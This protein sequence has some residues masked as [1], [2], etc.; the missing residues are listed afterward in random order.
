MLTN[1]F[2]INEQSHVS[3]FLKEL[4]D[5]K[6][7]HYIILDSN[8][9]YFVDIRSIALSID[10]ANEKLKRFKKA[11]SFSNG[12]SN[13]E[14][15]TFLINSGDKVI[16]TNSGLFDFIEGLR[17]IVDENMDL[18]NDK[19][20]SIDRDKIFALNSE[21]LISNARALLV[22]NKIN[23][24]PVIN[25]NHKLLGEVRTVDFLSSGLHIPN[26]QRGD[27]YS[28]KRADSILNL[29]VENIM[30]PKP[31]TIDRK[32][33]IK[34]VIQIMINK[35]L[36][37][38]IVV[39]ND[40]VHSVISYKD[41]FKSIRKNKLE[42]KSFSIEIIGTK[43]LFDDE[44]QVIEDY[45]NKSM[46]KI[47]KVSN[48][49][50]LRIKFKPLGNTLGTHMKKYEI[51]MLLSA[52]NKVL[53]VEREIIQGTSDEEFNDK[54]KGKWNLLQIVQEGLHVLEKKVLDVK[55]RSH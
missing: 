51:K 32:A 11:L 49:N 5:K 45:A 24:L 35:N 22:K 4:K 53:T 2:Q 34:D 30:N 21:D 13:V 38:L 39:D 54:V 19:I 15:L 16:E 55:K 28:E 14:H 43:E 26:S 36:E 17:T 3:S 8:P 6:N 9:K 7:T 47:S 46:N 44:I 23:I 10:S 1:Y 48:F 27:M 31:L 40:K 25:S 41:I 29:S 50:N 33:K 18:L 20:E 37:N 12:T 52:G 42:K